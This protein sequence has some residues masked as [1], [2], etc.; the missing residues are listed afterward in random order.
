MVLVYRRVFLAGYV[1]NIREKVG[2]VIFCTGRGFGMR[3]RFFDL[4]EFLM[5]RKVVKYEVEKLVGR[6]F[7][8]R[9]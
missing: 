9:R 6:K 2:F 3:I 8:R 1:V 5:V 4:V 7:G